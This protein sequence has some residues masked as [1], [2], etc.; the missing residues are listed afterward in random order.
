MNAQTSQ[1]KPTRVVV[2]DLNEKTAEDVLLDAAA[3]ISFERI[4]DGCEDCPDRKIALRRDNSKKFEKATVIQIDLR[5]KT[6]RRGTL[7]P[8]FFNQ[9]LK[10]IEGQNYFGMKNQYAMSVEGSAI[11]TMTV[12][13]AE[14]R[15][16]IKTTNEGEVPIQLWGIY[17]A[18]EGAMAH[19]KWESNGERK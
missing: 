10:L 19:V 8:Y 5:S 18:I 17:Y 2:I 14:K 12:N 4:F 11:V 13:L 6:E 9:L 15:K 16:T 1:Q 7:D 3:E